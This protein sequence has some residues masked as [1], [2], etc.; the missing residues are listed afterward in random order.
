MDAEKLVT[1]IHA[2]K[3]RNTLRYCAGTLDGEECCAC[4]YEG[5]EVELMF[6]AAHTIERLLEEVNNLKREKELALR[7]GEELNSELEK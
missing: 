4:P 1:E 3:V 5:C 2:E 6:D 7:G